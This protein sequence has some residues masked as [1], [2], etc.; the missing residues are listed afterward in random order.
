MEE[1]EAPIAAGLGGKGEG[2]SEQGVQLG[3]G[4]LEDGGD[5]RSGVGLAVA[6]RTTVGIGGSVASKPRLCKS[7]ADK[8]R[9]HRSLAGGPR[10]RKTTTAGSRVMDVVTAG[11]G[12]AAP[13]ATCPGV[14]DPTAAGL[15][16]VDLSTAGHVNLFSYQL[17]RVINVVAAPVLLLPTPYQSYSC[18]SNIMWVN[19]S[20]T[21]GGEAWRMWPN[22]FPSPSLKSI[23]RQ[24]LVDAAGSLPT[25]LPRGAACPWQTPAA[26]PKSPLASVAVVAFPSPFLLLATRSGNLEVGGRQIGPPLTS[27]PPW[28]LPPSLSVAVTSSTDGP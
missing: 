26:R 3:Q 15:V 5:G 4:D 12:A 13:S 22:P 19:A 2:G 9:E 6:A 18:G 23:W 24:G 8:P 28:L 21:D 1:W 14:V 16:S 17:W 7:V 20:W 25:S 11:L 10:Q 27:P